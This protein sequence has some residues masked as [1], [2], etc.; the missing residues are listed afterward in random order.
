MASFKDSCRGISVAKSGASIGQC[1][2]EGLNYLAGQRKDIMAQQDQIQ[3]KI[4]VQNLLFLELL[5][6]SIL[7]R[8]YAEDDTRKQKIEHVHQKFLYI[9]KTRLYV[10]SSVELLDAHTWRCCWM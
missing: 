3:Q 5:K 7:Y 4:A 8:E 10:N 1:D 2:S 9:C 6:L